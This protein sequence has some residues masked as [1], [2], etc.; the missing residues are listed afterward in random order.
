MTKP[1]RKSVIHMGKRRELHPISAEEREFFEKLYEEEKNF[2]FYIAGKYTQSNSDREDI[3]Q[4]SVLRLLNNISTLKRLD[5]FKVRKY[6]VLTIKA[7]SLDYEKK[8]RVHRMILISE[9]MLET[10]LEADIVLRQTGPD[11]SVSLLVEQLKSQ[12][13][14]REWFVLEGRYILGYSQEEL[15]K[16]LGVNPNSVRM[17]ICRARNKARD[18]LYPANARGGLEHE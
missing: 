10:M 7:V 2:M 16:L 18:I 17:I 14:Q 5:C 6:I 11:D 3:V 9:E 1:H 12:L 8:K 4:E 15:G 13:S